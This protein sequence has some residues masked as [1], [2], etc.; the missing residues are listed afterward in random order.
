MSYNHHHTTCNNV[1][2]LQWRWHYSSPTTKDFQLQQCS[3]GLERITGQQTVQRAPNCRTCV[4]FCETILRMVQ[5]ITHT[6]TPG[7]KHCAWFAPP[8]TP[9]RIH[10]VHKVQTETISCVFTAATHALLVVH[11]TCRMRCYWLRTTN[12]TG[13]DADIH[14]VRLPETKP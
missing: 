10:S 4:L 7:A 14:H 11:D 3:T 2:W 9:F 5:G 13:R 1:T 8:H 6:T 12:E